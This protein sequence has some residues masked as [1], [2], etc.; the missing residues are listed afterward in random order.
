MKNCFL[1]ILLFGW[2]TSCQ[3]FETE[4]IST[5]TF[6]EEELKTINWQDVDQYPAFSQCENTSEKL[7]QKACFE[8]VLSTRIYEYIDSKKIVAQ[9]ELNDTVF[10]DFSIDRAATLSVNQI[11]MDSLLQNEFPKMEQW[12]QE[13]VDSVTIVAPAFKRGIPVKTEFRLP[14]II[15][16]QE[17]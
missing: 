14:I 17:L 7:A 5:E 1:I 6:Y 4:K 9:R 10:L 2:V 3:F 15:K 13:S 16:T 8:R 12:L 11:K